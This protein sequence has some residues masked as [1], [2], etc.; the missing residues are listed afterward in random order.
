V[1]EIRVMKKPV[2]MTCRNCGS[3]QWAR[4]E[5]IVIQDVRNGD[6][7]WLCPLCRER[8]RMGSPNE[9]RIVIPGP[10]QPQGSSRAFVRGGKAIITSANPKLSEWRSLAV[11]FIAQ[12]R[13]RLGLTEPWEGPVEVWVYEERVKPR[14]AGKR[15]YPHVRPDLDKVVRACLDALVAGQAIRDDSQVCFISASKYYGAEASVCI[16]CQMTEG[17]TR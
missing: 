2:R 9:L 10:G 12:E 11:L 5:P 3:K 7:I 13:A 8:S 17:G 1:T 14:G 6:M 15:E 4:L 16:R